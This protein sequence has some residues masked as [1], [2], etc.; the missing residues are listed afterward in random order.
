MGRIRIV[1]LPPPM[2]LEKWLDENGFTICVSRSGVD[3]WVAELEAN[4]T[5]ASATVTYNPYAMGSITAAKTVIEA[6][7]QLVARLEGGAFTRK[8][9][10]TRA[11]PKLLDVEAFVEVAEREHGSATR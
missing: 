7:R 4:T 10:G 11:I 9:I 5:E 8:S 1:D 6:V 3:R 2:T